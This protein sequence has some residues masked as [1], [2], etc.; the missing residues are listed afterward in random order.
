MKKYLVIMLVLMMVATSV[1]TGCK[2]TDS[3]GAGGEAKTE[4]SK[5]D[6]KA[7]DTTE[8]KTEEKTA[9]EVVEIRV[10]WWGSETRH[11][12]TLNAITK[13][14]EMNPN[15]KVI[16]EYQG[17]DG[18][19]DKLTAQVLAGNAPD[20]FSCIGEWYPELLQAEAL[21]DLTGDIDVSGHNPRYVEACSI[22]GSMYGVNLS[23]NGKVI[24]ANKT[25]LD[26]LGVEML[27][28][29]YTWEDLA[30]KFAEV[31]EKSG[32]A[33]YGAPDFSVNIGGMGYPMFADY[34]KAALG[35]EGPIP[36]DNEKYTMTQDQIQAYYQ[37]WDDLRATNGV[38]PADV[39]A[40]NDFS[41]NSLLVQRVVAF[42][43]NFS[44]TFARFQD[45]MKDELVMIPFPVGENG[46][47]A[48]SA[49]PGIILSV[50]DKSEQ[51]E[52]A[53]KFVDFMTNT[54]EAAL[55]LKTCRGVLPT[56]VQRNALIEEEGVLSEN[57]IKVMEVVNQIMERDLNQFYAGPVGNGELGTIFVEA[58]Q[59]IA[60]G[61]ITVAEGA[62]KFMEQVGKLAD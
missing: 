61:K 25:L 47:N 58:G 15:I 10:S 59:E 19:K 54:K 45:Q 23:V 2:S 21:N 4:E 12:N 9:D 48:D 39:S 41:A 35:A 14:E 20:V 5:N 8:D 52:A 55:E 49:R 26:E 53:I 11:A 37:F 30:D 44:G 40:M 17:W 13:F 36:F 28:E 1:L 33:I 34:A 16:P 57:D 56:E 3:D 27:Q 24:I 31:Y 43:S 46:E 7:E 6:S 38:A 60:F 51:K 29:P 50:F 22:D 62:E 18:Y 32:G 42:E